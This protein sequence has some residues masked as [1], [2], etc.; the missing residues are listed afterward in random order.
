MNDAEVL[1][2]GRADDN[3]DY[4]TFGWQW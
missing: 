2:E 1:E 3:D 4:V